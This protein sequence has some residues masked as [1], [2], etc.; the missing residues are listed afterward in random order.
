M[1]RVE[2]KTDSP[3]ITRR[4]LLVDGA[5]TVFGTIASLWS[6]DQYKNPPD[7]PVYNRL[8]EIGNRSAL[9]SREVRESGAVED[10]LAVSL[11]LLPTTYGEVVNPNDPQVKEL[12][13]LYK[14]EI[15][16]S[17]QIEE[18][19]GVLLSRTRPFLL[20]FGPILAVMGACSLLD[21]YSTRKKDQG[22][23][24]STDNEVSTN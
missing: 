11:I 15:Q 19:E 7:T 1:E 3:G 20:V 8:K 12:T 17:R 14:E 23:V 5:K 4:R 2:N 9:L 18:Q 21:D 22:K 10:R 24:A 6:Y 16:L 13:A